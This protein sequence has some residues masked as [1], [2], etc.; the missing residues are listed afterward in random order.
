MEENRN[1]KTILS[2]SQAETLSNIARLFDLTP[3]FVSNIHKKEFGKLYEQSILE[4][5]EA[6]G[7]LRDPTITKALSH[8]KERLSFSDGDAAEMIASA[9]KTKLAPLVSQLLHDFDKTVADLK[10]SPPPIN[11]ATDAADAGED[12]FS[13]GGV[14]SGDLGIEMSSYGD[15]TTVLPTDILAMIDFYERNGLM[16]LGPDGNITANVTIGDIVKGEDNLKKLYTHF[17]TQSFAAASPQLAAYFQSAQPKLAAALGLAP[18]ITTKIASE[19]AS[20]L[21][22]KLLHENMKSE[23]PRPL[24]DHE[25][26]ML[27]Q[28]R[29]K[30]GLTDEDFQA[31]LSR[32]T[33]GII[34]IAVERARSSGELSRS[35]RRLRV[36]CTTFGVDV[37][38]DLGMT[39]NQRKN[40]LEAEIKE[41]VE[42]IESEKIE[43]DDLQD[44]AEELSLPPEDAAE[45][46]EKVVME[47]S[48]NML[49]SAGMDVVRGIESRAISATENLLR[50]LRLTNEGIEVEAGI[51]VTPTQKLAVYNLY[52]NA[53]LHSKLS[54]TEIV[55]VNRDLKL[56]MKALALE[57]ETTMPGGG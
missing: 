49:A 41:A 20:N 16:Y 40:L 53:K 51:D 8:L 42:N 29:L 25:H 39:L 44:I 13:H 34:A 48:A 43:R 2:P 6:P 1:R 35:V 45:C 27:A 21:V 38:L 10:N 31:L 12:Y 18:E 7:G 5:F 33:K 24:G 11:D 37:E 54:R 15:K 46:V 14:P 28:L 57:M 26:K 32:T 17:L 47:G 56:L 3:E 36:L 30:L 9:S 22:R 23:P 4:S 50:Y 52:K 19:M 55:K